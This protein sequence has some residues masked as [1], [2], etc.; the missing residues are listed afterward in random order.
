MTATTAAD[1]F[2][3]I[4]EKEDELKLV[5]AEV[6][7]PDMNRYEFI[8]KMTQVSKLPLVSKSYIDNKFRRFNINSWTRFL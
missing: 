3:I 7:L 6:H 5:L 1:A 8:E 2:S 4:Q